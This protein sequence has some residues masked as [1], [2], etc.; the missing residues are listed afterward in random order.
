M[1]TREPVGDSYINQ[2][3][4]IG[5]AERGLPAVNVSVSTVSAGAESPTEAGPRLCGAPKQRGRDR[6]GRTRL[7]LATSRAA[8]FTLHSESTPMLQPL[9]S[10]V[11][12]AAAI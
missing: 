4:I 10:S 1:A 2:G 8:R 11:S 5:D 3:S 6:D 12:R 7:G 9:T